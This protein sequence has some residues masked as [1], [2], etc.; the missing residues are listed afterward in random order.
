M[1]NKL[2]KVLRVMAVV[3]GGCGILVLLGFVGSIRSTAVCEAMDITFAGGPSGLVPENSVRTASVVEGKVPVGMPLGEIDTRSIEDA[4]LELPYVK[5]ASVYKTIDRKLIAEVTER[6]PA[7]RLIDA[8]GNHAVMDTEGYLLP[9]SSDKVARMPV[10]SGAFSL[11]GEAIKGRFHVSDEA[12]D[13]RLNGCFR[14]AEQLRSDPFWSAQ[15]QHTVVDAKGNFT[16]HPQVGNHTIVFGYPVRLNEK[17]DA[18]SVF[19]KKGMD[20]SRW[21]KY[22]TINLKFKDQIVCT[23]K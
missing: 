17:F 16:A 15:L 14:Y 6:V 1:K 13:A 22:S 5:N 23:K 12:V 21:N 2:Q 10:I 11:S 9:V 8:R 18:L 7:V 20:A 4:V 3:L 19:Y